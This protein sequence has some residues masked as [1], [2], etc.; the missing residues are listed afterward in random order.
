MD[1]YQYRC[2]LRRTL[3]K[4]IRKTISLCILISILLFGIIT[5]IFL[6]SMMKNEF[7]A[8]ANYFGNSIAQVINSKEFLA[9]MN[10]NRIEDLDVNSSQ[11][12]QWLQE[13]WE[14]ENRSLDYFI[15]N[16]HFMGGPKVIIQIDEDG[17]NQGTEPTITQYFKLRGLLKTTIQFGD[18]VIYPFP[19]EVQEEERNLWSMPEELPSLMKK[20][21]IYFDIHY[22]E[23]Y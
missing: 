17:N 20:L 10:V 7:S 23:N 16:E 8:I 22:P 19:I 6:K 18:E 15:G 14:L 2:M 3:S 21:R 9:E 5:G 4:R 13:L 12:H 1:N 11:V